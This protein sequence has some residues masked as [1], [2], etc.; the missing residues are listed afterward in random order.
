MQRYTSQ[1]VERGGENE[2]GGCSM[3]FDYCSY[4]GTNPRTLAGLV[5]AE[6]IA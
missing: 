6:D 4:A 3:M 2:A 5:D 1:T